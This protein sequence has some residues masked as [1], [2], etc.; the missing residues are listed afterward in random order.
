VTELADLLVLLHGA[1]GRISTVRATVRTWYD[2]VLTQKAIERDGHATTYGPQID[3]REREGL[4]RVW[5]APPDRAREERTGTDG[6][7]YGVRLGPQWWHYDPHNG[8]RSNEDRPE[9]T[10]GTGD[11]VWWLLEP[12]PLIGLLDFHDITPGRR[13]DRATIG[14]RAVPRAV[15]DGNNWPLA[16]LGAM[17]ADEILL[18]I[19]AERGA[20][21]RIESRLEGQPYAISEVLEVAFDEAFADD[22]FVFTPPPGEEVRSLDDDFGIFRDLTIEQ[23]VARA[24]FTVWIASQLPAGWATEITF[25]PARDRP[26]MA[27]TLYLNYRAGDGTHAVRVVE[28]PADHPGEHDEYEHARPNPWQEVERNGRTM[29]IREPAESWQPAQLLA[30]LDGTRI[31]IHSDDLAATALADLAGGLVPAP[32]EPPDLGR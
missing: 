28:S 22:V 30:E 9:V 29:Q 25:A 18:E 13:A 16:R 17:G 10:T 14:T 8:A 32:A 15:G 26:A 2:I 19:D 3:E 23:A 6:E 7:G 4:V 24:P 27:P 20:L 11:D 21:L 5:L 12:A 1:R 31:L